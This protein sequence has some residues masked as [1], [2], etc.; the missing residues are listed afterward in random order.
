MN[1]DITAKE[2]ALVAGTTPKAMRR[3]IRAADEGC[4]RGNRYAFSPAEAKAIIAAF[5]TAA[6][7][8]STTAAPVRS[9]DELNELLADDEG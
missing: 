9:L 6:A 2:L 8:R 3:F 7:N 4:G 5:R 1:N